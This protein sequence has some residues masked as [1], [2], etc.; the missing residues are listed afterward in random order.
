MRLAERSR[1]LGVPCPTGLVLTFDS[2]VLL[3]SLGI[4]FLNCQFSAFENQSDERIGMMI[5]NAASI[6][7]TFQ[8]P[9]K[10]SATKWRRASLNTPAPSR[11]I[12]L[13]SI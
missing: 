12:V 10:K 6:I 13:G 11:K 4:Y 9:T 5:R 3:E 7:V 1:P 8:K 2:P